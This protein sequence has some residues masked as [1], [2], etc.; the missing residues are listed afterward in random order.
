MNIKKL[1]KQAQ[2]MQEEMQQRLKTVE[3]EGSAGGG[4][5]K[6]VV[7]GHKELLRV[8]LD[9]EIL[10]PEER[11]MVEDLV[12]AAVKDAQEKAEAQVQGML[13]ALTGGM[14]F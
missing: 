6:A 8:S 9:A 14:G 12:L 1:M 11:E 10:K 5:V 2:Q 4:V 7:N 3:V 13:G